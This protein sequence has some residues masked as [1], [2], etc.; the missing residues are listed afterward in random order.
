M[1]IVLA[2]LLLLGMSSTTFAAGPLMR[3]KP[4]NDPVPAFATHGAYVSVLGVGSTIIDLSNDTAFSV[5]CTNGGWVRYMPSTTSTK[6]SYVKV[7]VPL[8]TWMTE[9]VH[10]ATPFV[11]FSGCSTGYLKRM[12]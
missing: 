9:G 10:S 5:Y 3:S 2:I 8:E 4:G 1:K 6:A 12:R 11:N 7:P